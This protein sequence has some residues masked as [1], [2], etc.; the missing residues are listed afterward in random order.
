M[1]QAIE[2]SDFAL[3]RVAEHHR[4]L[5]SHARRVLIP[6]FLNSGQA[7]LVAQ[8]SDERRGQEERGNEA[9][10]ACSRASG[11]H[12]REEHYNSCGNGNASV[13]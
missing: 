10:C 2:E 6:R 11:G 1:R 5:L 12:D 3:H 9:F 13:E 4:S 8:R 7:A